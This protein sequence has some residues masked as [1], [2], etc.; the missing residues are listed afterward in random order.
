MSASAIDAP[1]TAR[2]FAAVAVDR[3]VLAA[4]HA[5]GV[6]VPDLLPLDELA[7]RTCNSTYRIVV[8][9][10]D[11]ARI[12]VQGGAFFPL[13]CH[14]HLCGGTLGGSLLK[15]HWIGCG[16]H[17]EILHEGRR[18]VTTRVRSIAI[19]PDGARAH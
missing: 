16:F 3:F 12:L 5:D 11:D 17:L 6:H 7:V 15:L 14:A 10:P 9:A 13:P 4:A 18:I 1:R 8:V 19:N 2:P